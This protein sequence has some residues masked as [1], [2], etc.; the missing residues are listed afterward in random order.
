MKYIKDNKHSIFH[1]SDVPVRSMGSIHAL[2]IQLVAT[3]IL[4]MSISDTNKKNLGKTDLGYDSVVIGLGKTGDQVNIMID[5]YWNTLNT[6]T[7]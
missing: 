2:C 6:V 7:T 4:E 3:G 5:P 1:E